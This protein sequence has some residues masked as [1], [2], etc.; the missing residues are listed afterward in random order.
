MHNPKIMLQRIYKVNLCQEY[1]Q[2]QCVV[3]KWRIEI[4]E[5]TIET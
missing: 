3:V 5:Y 4:I 2:T 1:L